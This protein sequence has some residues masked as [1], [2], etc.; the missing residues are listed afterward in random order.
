MPRT[1][2]VLKPGCGEARA[3]AG[4]LRRQ[5][6]SW[7]SEAEL[8]EIQARSRAPYENHDPHRVA[9]WWENRIASA[10]EA[11]GR[12]VANSRL[13]RTVYRGP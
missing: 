10:M 13:Q 9:A 4:L 5:V 11:Y 6:R 2:R 3:A 8:S 1:T 7:Y 12:R